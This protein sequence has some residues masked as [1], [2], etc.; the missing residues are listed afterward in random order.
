MFTSSVIPVV[1]NGRKLGLQWNFAA[2]AAA[3]K[4]FH[5]FPL[6][7]AAFREAMQSYAREH[8]TLNFYL[9]LG[10]CM[11]QGAADAPTLEE[12]GRMPAQDA[13]VFIDAVVRAVELGKTGG[14]EKK[15]AKRRQA[16]K[17]GRKK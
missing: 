9:A 8:S 4:I 6:D 10:F 13:Y 5:C 7:T 14:L 11:L 2:L 3:E 16:A 12:L 15:S 1:V 17:A